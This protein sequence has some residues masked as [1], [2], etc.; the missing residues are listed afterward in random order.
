MRRSLLLA[1]AALALPA[2]PRPSRPTAHAV[3]GARVLTV[4]GASYER[5]TVVMRDGLIEA[6]GPTSCR[7][8]GH[9]SSTGRASW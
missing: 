5:A 8:P 9:A 4:S 2:P 6:V 3:V 1:A 7:P